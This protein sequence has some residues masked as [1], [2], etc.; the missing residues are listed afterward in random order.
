MSSNKKIAIVGAGLIGRAWATQFAGA[1]FKVALYDPVAG[2]AKAA[3]AFV[4]R[5]LKELEG[6]D[7]VKDAAAALERVGVAKSLEEALDGA[8][9]VQE[10][11][12]EVEDVKKATF[13][14]MDA[15]AA[16]G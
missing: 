7:L 4:G 10:N 5:S 3:R 2:V 1:G 8:E 15:I 12:P 11:G 14:E 16:P 6:F 9:L 13:A